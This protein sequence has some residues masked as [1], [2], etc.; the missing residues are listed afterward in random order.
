M[1]LVRVSAEALGVNIRSLEGFAWDMAEVTFSDVDIK[2][3]DF[4]GGD[5]NGGWNALERAIIKTIPV[6]SSYQTGG[7]QAVYEI[8]VGY[9]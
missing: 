2:Q 4:L 3:S 5:L 7:C 9:S 8:S 6:L 1:G